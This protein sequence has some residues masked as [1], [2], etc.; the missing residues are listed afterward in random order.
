MLYKLTFTSFYESLHFRSLIVIPY[1]VSLRYFEAFLHVVRNT[2]MYA[3]GDTERL[4]L[5]IKCNKGLLKNISRCFTRRRYELFQLYLQKLKSSG[6][7]KSVTFSLD[8]MAHV[9]CELK[10]NFNISH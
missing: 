4:D 6:T 7:Y 1:F 2:S 10:K 3:E 5:Q 8:A 9:V